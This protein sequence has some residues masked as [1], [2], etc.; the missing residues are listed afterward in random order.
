MAGEDLYQW[1][2]GEVVRGKRRSIPAD[3]RVN[4][5]GF[6]T[7]NMFERERAGAA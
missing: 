2:D 1:L 4:G 5:V 3:R 7:R 6:S